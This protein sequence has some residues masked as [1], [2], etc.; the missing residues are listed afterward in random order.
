MDYNAA[1]PKIK[2]R[3]VYHNKR[4]F[5]DSVHFHDKRNT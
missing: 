2:I 5:L 3:I 4:I 1:L